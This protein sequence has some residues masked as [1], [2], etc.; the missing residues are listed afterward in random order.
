MKTATLPPLRVD[1]ELR[2]AA[3]GVLQQGES[4]SSF[5]TH[6]IR[7]GIRQR[8]MDAEFLARGM[9]SRDEARRSGRYVSAAAV[10]SE[11][12]RRLKRSE[13]RS[14]AGR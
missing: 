11:L 5:I 1:P 10:L 12:D 2:S 4:L 3:E 6:S 14:K 13:A 7:E 8:R 9:A